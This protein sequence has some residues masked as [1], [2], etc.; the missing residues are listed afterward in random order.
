VWIL[1][2]EFTEICQRI[3][4]LAGA[5]QVVDFLPFQVPQVFGELGVGPVFVAIGRGQSQA[6]PENTRHPQREH[7]I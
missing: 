2:E 5:D 1:A 3:T 7:Q 4:S 6:H